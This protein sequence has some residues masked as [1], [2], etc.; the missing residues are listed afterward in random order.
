MRKVWSTPKNSN[1]TEEK[2]WAFAQKLM[3]RQTFIVGNDIIIR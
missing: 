3:N 1:D 2:A